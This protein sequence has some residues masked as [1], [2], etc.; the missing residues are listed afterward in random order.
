MSYRLPPERIMLRRFTASSQAGMNVLC[1]RGASAPKS[2][3]RQLPAPDASLINREPNYRL[4]L[5]VAQKTPAPLAD[6][7]AILMQSP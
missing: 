7:A 2:Y 5:A 6:A 1:Q 3:A 4:A